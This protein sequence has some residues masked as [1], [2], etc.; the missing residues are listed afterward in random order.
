MAI[1]FK[2]PPYTLIFPE[3]VNSPIKVSITY[4][5]DYWTSSTTLNYLT[6]IDLPK[7]LVLIQLHL[8]QIRW[9]R[10]M[11]KKVMQAG[12]PFL[13]IVVCIL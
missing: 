1:L 2:V 4:Q 13:L 3:T 11:V 10:L 5:F 9:H 8:D 12:D 7:I 6:L